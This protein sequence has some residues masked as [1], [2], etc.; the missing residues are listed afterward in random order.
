MAKK[1]IVIAVVTVMVFG[2]FGLAGCT[3]SKEDDMDWTLIDSDC[4]KTINPTKT[5]AYW[6]NLTQSST[7][8]ENVLTYFTLE[9]G[10]Y[11]DDF[12]GVFIDENGIYN[13]CVVGNRE[14]IK[15][16]YLIYKRVDNAYNFLES[17]YEEIGKN[18]LEYSIW[19]IEICEYCNK[20]SIY[21]ENESKIPLIVEHLKSIELFKKGTLNI[22]VGQNEIAPH[23]CCDH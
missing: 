7:A 4:C 3:E 17:I 6:E 18:S 9:D 1:L 11:S 13:V 8:F 22:Y 5:E 20:V 19:M 16:D 12:G 21:L 14:P 10:K 23:T 2:V 15:S